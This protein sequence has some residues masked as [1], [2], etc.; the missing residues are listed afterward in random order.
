VSTWREK[1]VKRRGRYVWGNV[2]RSG[3]QEG[4]EGKRGAVLGWW[5]RKAPHPDPAT[6]TPPENN[7]HK[8]NAVAA[9]VGETRAEEG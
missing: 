9:A 7:G 3:D 5:D 2:I 4:S 1:T 6:G 8:V